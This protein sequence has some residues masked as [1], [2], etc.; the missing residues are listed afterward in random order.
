MMSTRDPA[1]LHAPG[2]AFEN[3]TSGERVE[4]ADVR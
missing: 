3:D 1:A 2:T 4:G